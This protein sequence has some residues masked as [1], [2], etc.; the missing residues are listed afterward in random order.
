MS[1]KSFIGKYFPTKCYCDIFYETNGVGGYMR[2]A[3]S[4][5]KKY[6]SKYFWKTF[7][8]Y[9]VSHHTLNLGVCRCFN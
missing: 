2:G 4:L 7:R 8:R 5:P 1:P 6:F 9:R 3:N